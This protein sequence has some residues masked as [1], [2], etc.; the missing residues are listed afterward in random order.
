[1]GPR[2]CSHRSSSSYLHAPHKPKPLTHWRSS[3]SIDRLADCPPV[4]VDAGE[5]GVVRRAEVDD[6][7]NAQV[8]ERT[9]V[10]S[11]SKASPTA[12]CRNGSSPWN[13]STGPSPSSYAPRTCAGPLPLRK[14]WWVS[15]DGYQRVHR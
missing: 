4:V 5:S 15:R 8:R 14:S 3:L 7:G 6:T 1:M 10:L 9:R 11:E 13:G 2:A 12:L